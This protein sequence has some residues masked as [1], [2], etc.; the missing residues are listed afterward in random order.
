M[1]KKEIKENVGKVIRFYRQELGLTIDDFSKFVKISPTFL[2]LIE[3]GD[4]CT[5]L[6]N[7]HRI[8]EFIEIPVDNMINGITE[9][10]IIKQKKD[11]E[12][13]KKILFQYI[14]GLNSKGTKFILDIIKSYFCNL[15]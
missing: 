1:T 3:R 5:N 9:K 12:P 11:Y 7:L 6:E 4:R 14:K 13:E 15:T 2:G 8:S 10:N